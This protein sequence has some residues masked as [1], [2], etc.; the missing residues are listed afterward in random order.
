HGLR[1]AGAMVGVAVLVSVALRRNGRMLQRRIGGI[2]PALDDELLALLRRERAGEVGNAGPS[3]QR[4]PQ[5]GGGE[6]TTAREIAHMTSSSAG[7]GRSTG[8]GLSLNMRP[9]D[10]FF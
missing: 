10:Q 4:G 1:E 9:E 5:C 7:R 2:A 6:K 3:A 8:Y